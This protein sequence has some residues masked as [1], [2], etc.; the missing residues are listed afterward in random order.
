MQNID[1]L[2]DNL[3][4]SIQDCADVEKI[5]AINNVKRALHRISPFHNEP[6][7]CVTWVPASSVTAN[8]YNPNNVAPPEM[9]LLEHSISTDGYTQ[10]VVVWST[11]TATE[12]VDG[13]HR[14]KVA[15]TSS[16]VQQRTK[17]Y[18]PVV[19]VNQDRTDTSDR[20][21]S[22]I[23]HNRARGKHA[24]QPMSDIVTEL[25]RRGWKKE[26]IA[27]ELGMDP[28]EVVRLFQ[29]TGLVDLFKD[30][31]FSEAWGVDAAGR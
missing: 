7:D 4:S 3:I 21:A 13:F 19:A 26:K 18:I 16:L 31:D 22:T 29:I 11:E 6:V 8:D 1:A 28:D 25:Y 14:T 17:G 20:M 15:K 24:V 12:V 30:A 27:Q 2:I 10:P 23:R 9:K 5:D